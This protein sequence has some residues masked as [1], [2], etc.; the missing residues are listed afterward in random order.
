MGR[1]GQSHSCFAVDARSR[2]GNRIVSDTLSL[3]GYR[4]NNDGH[5]IEV[6]YLAATVAHVMKERAPKPILML[7]FRGFS[8][9]RNLPVE[10]PLGTLGIWGATKGSHTDQMS[11]RVAISALTDKPH[12]TWIGEA[13]RFLRL[14]HQGLAFAHGGRLQTPR[15]D[16]IEGNTV[17]ATF[18]SGSGYRPEFPVPHSL[19]HDPIIGALVRRYFER[20]PL[21]DVLGTALGWMQTDTTFDEVR[22]L[23]A[24]TAVETI[25]ESELPGR[26]GTVIAKSKFK[27]LRQKLEEATDHDP[28]LSANER[29][30]SR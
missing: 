5:F 9:F 18:F 29:A 26:R 6:S 28:N 30:I 16:L 20:G 12:T 7:W 21:S 8:S 25:I 10:T 22:F 4:A 23:T 15:L 14:M 2:R 13:D 11:G 1:P 27:V 3:T 24:M 17:T 19:D